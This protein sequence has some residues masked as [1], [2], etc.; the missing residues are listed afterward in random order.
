MHQ[1][2]FESPYTFGDE[3]EF[4]APHASG[5][6]RVLDIVLCEDRSVYYLVDCDNGDIHGGIL[7]QLMRPATRPPQAPS[8]DG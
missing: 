4:S 8:A 6:G 7:P 3:V 1:F 2:R 5:R